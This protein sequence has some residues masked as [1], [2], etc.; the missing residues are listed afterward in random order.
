[1]KRSL[2]LLLPVTALVVLLF[3]RGAFADAAGPGTCFGSGSHDE[4]RKDAG[5]QAKDGLAQGPSRSTTHRAGIG[6]VSAA[7]ITSGW[8]FLRR[9]EPKP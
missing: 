6:L 7:F 5:A 2:A 3:A 4:Y 8:L 1:M 9:R